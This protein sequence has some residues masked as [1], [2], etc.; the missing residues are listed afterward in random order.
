MTADIDDFK[1]VWQMSIEW[2]QLVF[3][4]LIP[5]VGYDLKI[6]VGY[7]LYGVLQFDSFIS[8]LEWWICQELE[9]IS[10]Y[11]WIYEDIMMM[12]I[13]ITFL[14]MEC[15]PANK[16][17]CLLHQLVDELLEFRYSELSVITPLE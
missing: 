5:P 13:M 4:W 11:E 7:L 12:I 6:V 16:D 10:F 15:L 8:D 2:G 3:D 1:I 17:Y 14:M 9:I